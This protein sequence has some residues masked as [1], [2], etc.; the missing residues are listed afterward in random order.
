MFWKIVPMMV[1]VS[2]AGTIL[3]HGNATIREDARLREALAPA[4]LAHAFEL[5]LRS[6]TSLMTQKE[7]PTL[8]CKDALQVLTEKALMAALRDR[9]GDANENGFYLAL[10]S[11]RLAVALHAP[12]GG[13]CAFASDKVDTKE[14]LRQ[15][16]AASAELANSVANRRIRQ[17]ADGWISAATVT[18]AGGSGPALTVGVYIVSP[19]TKL[20]RETSLV[21]AL[22][23]FIL[24]LN[25]SSAFI[26]VVL[27]IRRIERANKA[28]MAWATGELS[29]RIHDKGFDELSRLAQQFDSMADAISGVIEIKQALATAE[30][31]NR[32]ARE[33]HDSAKQRAFALNLQLTAA[34]KMD[35]PTKEAQK[36]ISAALSLTSQLQ[37]DLAKVIRRLAAPTITESGFRHVLTESIDTMLAGS[38]IAWSIH[39]S[40]DHERLLEAKPELSRDLFLITIEAVANVLKHANCTHCSICVEGTGPFYTLRVADDGSGLLQTDSRLHGMGLANMRL[41]AESLP[42]GKLTIV[43]EPGRGTALVVRFRLTKPE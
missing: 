25:A 20:T 24:I 19:F 8:W 12:H 1:L 6:S 18:P 26:L 29:A 28:A 3:L 5:A 17:V 4:E 36:L 10:K 30:E 39:L 31:R 9:A 42:D 40:D 43:S 32:L 41:R 37:Q 16:M 34:S 11:G 35:L 14:V 2:S 33:L 7:L 27:L 13:S 38:Q 22:A 15:Q 21:S 23:R